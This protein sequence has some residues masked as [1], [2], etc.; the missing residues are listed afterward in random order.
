VNRWPVRNSAS[1]VA[2]GGLVKVDG[3]VFDIGGLELLGH[4]LL[5]VA[6]GLADFEETCMRRV[7]DGVGVNTRPDDGL[8]REDLFNWPS[9]ARRLP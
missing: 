5:Y 1:T 3:V 7:C 6:R 9:H 4:A 2:L 8:G